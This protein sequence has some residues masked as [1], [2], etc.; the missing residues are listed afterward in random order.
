MGEIRKAIQTKGWAEV[1]F[2][3]SHRDRAEYAQQANGLI[4]TMMA[5]WQLND[6]MDFEITPSYHTVQPGKFGL[7]SGTHS[8]DNKLWLHLGYQS[9]ARAEAAFGGEAQQPRQLRRFWPAHEA[10]LEA[11][12]V[13][14]SDTIAALGARALVDAL[15][16]WPTNERVVHLRTVRYLGSA[17]ARAGQELVSGH[18]DMGVCT[19]HLFETHGG[20]MRAAPYPR[21]LNSRHDSPERQTAMNLVRQQMSPMDVPPEAAAFFLGA[22]WHNLSPDF[23]LHTTPRDLPACYHAGYKP[24]SS[25]ET[26]SEYAKQV[27]KKGDRVSVVAFVHPNV[28]AFMSALYAPP[29]V[30][31]CRGGSIV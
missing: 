9:R 13:S 10:M 31:Q 21:S 19:M 20:W 7:S 27:S 11:V 30:T 1:P 14:V 18:A 12:R 26:S 6:A 3:L 25:Q 8:G 15:Y 17:A 24:S 22:G 4:D 28:S 2:G 16:P 5:D 29:T 23:L